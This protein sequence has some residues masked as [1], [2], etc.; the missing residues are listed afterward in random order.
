[1][2]AVLKVSET[3]PHPK[4]DPANQREKKEDSRDLIEHILHYHTTQS[5]YT[6]YLLG[7][8]YSY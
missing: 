4:C 6:L 3:K 1:M 2:F 8:W 5:Q 7:S